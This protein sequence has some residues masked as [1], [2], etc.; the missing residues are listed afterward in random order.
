VAERALYYWNSEHLCV[1]VLS[2]SKA[3]IFLP[4]VFGPLSKSAAGHWNQAV[5]GLAQ[6]ILKMYMEMDIQLYDKCSRE[7]NEKLRKMESDR[8]ASQQ[9]WNLIMDSATSSGIDIS[10][11]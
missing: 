1:N 8:E 2:Q 6:S 3:S 9:K 4:Y 11:L 5:E 7:N 10:K